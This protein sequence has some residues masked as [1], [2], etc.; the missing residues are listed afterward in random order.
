MVKNFR[1]I[2]LIGISF[3][4]GILFVVQCGGA[5]K[6]IADAVADALDLNYSNSDSGLSATTVQGAIDELVDAIPF[7]YDSSGA[8]VGVYISNPGGG[9]W[10]VWDL[11]NQAPFTVEPSTGEIVGFSEDNDQAGFLY[12]TS[13]DCTGTGYLKLRGS[14]SG[15]GH[16]IKIGDTFYW[17][18]FNGETMDGS[19][20]VSAKRADGEC[21]VGNFGL[22]LRK[23]INDEDSSDA[24]V[25]AREITEPS[26]EGPLFIN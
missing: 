16:P 23:A 21:N 9:D 24:L 6:S 19:T 18:T 25:E 14:P 2:Y 13:E 20:M 3:I 26:Y 4:A 22:G 8:K 11:V 7:I 1:D 5:A 15:T 17:Y 10:E 12:F